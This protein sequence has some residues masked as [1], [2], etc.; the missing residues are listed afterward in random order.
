LPPND[1]FAFAV[2][3]L[4]PDGKPPRTLCH[5]GIRGHSTIG[6]VID[7]D[8][9]IAALP[10]DDAGYQPAIS[11]VVTLATPGPAVIHAHA[12]A[13]GI[14]HRLRRSGIRTDLRHAFTPLE[15]LE[16]ESAKAG[17][18]LLI[19]VG[20]DSTASTP[21]MTLINLTDGAREV[22]DLDELDRKVT[23]LLD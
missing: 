13:L 10:D 12:H 18:R 5:G 19:A 14:A 4:A 23:Q 22:A 7:V 2:T 9:V 11:V 1:A 20:G 8:A 15:E 6:F 3:C 17:V 21:T 16:A